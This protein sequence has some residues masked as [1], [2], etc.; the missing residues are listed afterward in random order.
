[1]TA[2]GSEGINLFKACATATRN[3]PRDSNPRM[4]LYRRVKAK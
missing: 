3:G 2:E 4:L 1:M